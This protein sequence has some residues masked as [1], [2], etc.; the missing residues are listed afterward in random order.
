MVTGSQSP[1]LWRI[2]W[3]WIYGIH[4][5]VWA[6]FLALLAAVVTVI[7][8]A[9]IA[10]RQRTH[11]AEQKQIERIMALRR[12][13]FLDGADGVTLA[14]STIAKI[15]DL[16]TPDSDIVDAASKVGR[17]LA[18][19]QVICNEE[20]S[21]AITAFSVTFTRAYGDLYIERL[22]IK[23]KRDEIGRGSEVSEEAFVDLQLEL[24]KKCQ[25]RGTELPALITDALFAV[26]D[27]LQIPTDKARFLKTQLTGLAGH[28]D[29][30]RALWK[31]LATLKRERFTQ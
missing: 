14:V 11:D 5:T 24:V 20:T 12:E 29:T 4:P 23:A 27:E 25:V 30:A 6:A 9:L 18:R 22:I 17:S 15:A 1:G 21:K 2:T 7:S 16:N 3:D 13:V 28:A 26:R 19:T 31:K 8:T 10:A